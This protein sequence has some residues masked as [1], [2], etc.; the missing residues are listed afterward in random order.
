MSRP[1]LKEFAAAV[2]LGIVIGAVPASVCSLAR[3]WREGESSGP[4]QSLGN[5][6]CPTG[7]ILT[8]GT[9]GRPICFDALKVSGS[10]IIIGGQ[11]EINFRK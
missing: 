10:S 3:E 1:S 2:G 5:D 4:P 9:D 11:K 8:G 6:L 7:T